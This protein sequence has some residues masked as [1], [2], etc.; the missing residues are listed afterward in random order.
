MCALVWQQ[1]HWL[2]VSQKMPGTK[3]WVPHQHTRPS[4]AHH[5][6]YLFAHVLGVAVHNALG[7]IWFGIAEHTALQSA[8]RIVK[9][10]IAVGASW[11]AVMMSGA[12]HVNHHLDGF[13]FTHAT[14]KMLVNSEFNKLICHEA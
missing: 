1:W 2:A 3:N 5:N 14:D 4:P 8:R 9:Q 11:H 13:K 6:P 12:V 7:T 10:V